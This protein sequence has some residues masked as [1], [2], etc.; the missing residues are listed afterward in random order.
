[1]PDWLKDQKWSIGI[2]ADGRSSRHGRDKAPVLAEPFK[3][4]AL[5][6]WDDANAHGGRPPASDGSGFGPGRGDCASGLMIG[7]DLR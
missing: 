7:C 4:S 5:H 2:C 1:M 6:I 3:L